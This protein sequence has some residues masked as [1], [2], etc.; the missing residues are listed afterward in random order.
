[1]HK[2]NQFVEFLLN[3]FQQSFRI[4]HQFFIRSNADGDIAVVAHYAYT[5]PDHA[6]SRYPEHEVGYLPAGK[7]EGL[8][9]ARH[10]GQNAGCLVAEYL[11]R[12][13]CNFGRKGTDGT[14]QPEINIGIRGNL[15]V[16]HAAFNLFQAQYR[17]LK[18]D[19]QSEKNQAEF[20]AKLKFCSGLS[21][22]DRNR[23]MNIQL[24]YRS[25]PCFQISSHGT[26]DCGNKNV[27]QGGGTDSLTYLFNII[28][29]NGC[30]PGQSFLYPEIAFKSG[31]GICR[32]N[33][34]FGQHPGKIR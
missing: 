3:A 13:P 31:S 26:G 22:I 30:S 29:G 4:R 10:I 19:R 32:H 33:G 21:D 2:I 27:I 5:Q 9:G 16:V 24:I 8:P 15:Q 28:K 14:Q 12:F 1:M 11:C 23:H 25:V 17:I 7:I 18:I 6:G 34:L 20:V